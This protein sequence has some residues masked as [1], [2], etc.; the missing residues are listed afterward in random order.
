MGG[1]IK[2]NAATPNTLHSTLKLLF[3]CPTVYVNEMISFK[4]TVKK[5][6][7][8]EHKI[9]ELN[10]LKNK[11]FLCFTTQYISVKQVKQI[12]E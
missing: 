1:D 3:K 6:K 9:I 10:I 2:L 8:I 7:A 5:I 11:S 4:A 12:C